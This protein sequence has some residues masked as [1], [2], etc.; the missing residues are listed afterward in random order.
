MQH[1][2][3]VI[4]R[5]TVR[6][7]GH[8]LV[9]SHASDASHR[10]FGYGPQPSSGSPTLQTAVVEP[11]V[12][13]GQQLGPTDH[14]SSPPQPQHKTP[15]SRFADASGARFSAQLHRYVVYIKQ[16][17]SQQQT[18]RVGDSKYVFSLH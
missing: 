4:E 14:R 2:C 8:R 1:R 11:A 17:S 15:E 9:D 13:V 16:G 18:L 3:N 7:V 10:S 6:L 12:G 5:F